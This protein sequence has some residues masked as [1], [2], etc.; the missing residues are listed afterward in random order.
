MAK[1]I[2]VGVSAVVN[3]AAVAFGS[4]TGKIL[5]ISTVGNAGTVYIGESGVDADTGMPILKDSVVTLSE[6]EDFDFANLYVFGAGATD[7]IRFTYL[8]R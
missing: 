1:G 8:A 7:R 3:G 6:E 2:K 4:G 5:M